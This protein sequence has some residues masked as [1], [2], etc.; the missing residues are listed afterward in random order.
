MKWAEQRVLER[1]LLRG[2]HL[3]G[4]VQQAVRI[5][6][7]PGAAAPVHAELEADRLAAL[8]D[9]LLVALDLLGAHAVF[10]RR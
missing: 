6:G 9:G 1:A 2:T 5:E 4:P 10:L 7:I 3:A 8:G